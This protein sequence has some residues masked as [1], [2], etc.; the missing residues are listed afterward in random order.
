MLEIHDGGER[1]APREQEVRVRREPGELRI[2]HVLGEDLDGAE[3]LLACWD[4]GEAV[5]AV[6]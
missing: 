3:R 6:R 5:V 1:V 4:D 2:P